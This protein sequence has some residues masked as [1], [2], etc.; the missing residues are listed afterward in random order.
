M[1]IETKGA[2][3][4]PNGYLLTLWNTYEQDWRPEQVYLTA[5]AKGASKGPHLHK[6]RIGRFV[7][8]KGAVAIIT[9]THK[10]PETNGVYHHTLIGPAYSTDVVEVPVGMPAE[11]RNIG[12]G[13]ALLI[14][15]PTPA[16]RPDD[17]DEWDVEE[18]NP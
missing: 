10:H 15:M 13:E 14:N 9:R 16:W 17:Q 18:W 7:C 8:I 3:G 12:E 6:K 4:E 1:R 5:I 11:L 2:N